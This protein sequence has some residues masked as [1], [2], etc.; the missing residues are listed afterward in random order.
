MI[1]SARIIIG[2]GCNDPFVELVAIRPGGGVLIYEQHLN[3]RRIVEPP[4]GRQGQP[5]EAVGGTVGSVRTAIP[6]IVGP[7]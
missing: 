4:R 3:R 2:S 1:P 6:A 5:V 7:D